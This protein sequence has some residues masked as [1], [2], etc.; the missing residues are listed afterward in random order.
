MDTLNPVN[1]TEALKSVSEHWSPRVLGRVNDQYIKVAKV[2]GQLVWHKHDHED[3]M[4]LVVYG[5]LKIELEGR[6]VTLNPGDFYVIPKNTLQN[7]V[8]EEEVGLV[9]IETVS[10]KHT[11][12]VVDPRTKTIEKQLEG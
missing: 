10:T 6:S 8:A 2:K 4:F 1:F 12:D 7:P 5:K 9:L 3:E 11:G